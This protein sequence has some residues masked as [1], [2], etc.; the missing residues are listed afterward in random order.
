MAAPHFALVQE[1]D[2]PD[3]ADLTAVAAAVQKQLVDDV[4]PMWGRAGTVSVFEALEQVPPGYWPV[5]VSDRYALPSL[6]VH[7][8]I[9]GTPFAL[10]KYTASY[11]QG[12]SHEIVEMVVDPSGNR[13]AYGP[14]RKEGQGYVGYLVEVCDPSEEHKN[15]YEIDGILLSDFYSPRYFDAEARPGV[16]YS[17]TRAIREPR[18]VLQG[19]YLSWRTADGRWWQDQQFGDA[20]GIKEMPDV[21]PGDVGLRVRIDALTQHPE[22]EHGL[23][24]GNRVLRR[25]VARSAQTRA[26]SERRAERLRERIAA[27]SAAS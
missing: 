7:R 21:D 16:R 1:V 5:L 6:G 2:E 12:V 11:S 13:I 25:A 4:L 23:A 27:L 14:S 26:E 3:I 9:D 10:I 15:G 17:F 24:P 8:E 18:E 20:P 22:L 19:G